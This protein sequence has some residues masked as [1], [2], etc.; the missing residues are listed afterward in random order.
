[1]PVPKLTDDLSAYAIDL[2]RP[3]LRDDLCLITDVVADLTARAV[4]GGADTRLARGVA[5]EHAL[6]ALRRLCR[7]VMRD[8]PDEE[9]CRD[10]GTAYLRRWW[11]RRPAAAEASSRAVYLHET[12]LPDLPPP[13]NHPW[14]SASLLVDGA[15]EDLEWAGEG[16]E[17]RRWNPR[18][19]DI[20]YRP[21]AHCHLLDPHGGAPA[22]TLFATGGREQAWGF[23]RPD[24][25]FG[26]DRGRALR[27]RRAHLAHPRP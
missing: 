4:S 23:L 10:G 21:A 19:G 2:P 8:D 26:R 13:H 16:L 3:S 20:L 24:G 12:V 11:L 5:G 15:L 9:L 27:G 14:A 7:E 17:P 22:L 1:M 25:T 6:L 18:P